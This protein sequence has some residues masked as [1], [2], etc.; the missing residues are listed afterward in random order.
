[1]HC[2]RLDDKFL[3]PI[4]FLKTTYKSE[5]LFKDTKSVFAVF[6]NGFSHTFGD[7][8]LNKVKMVDIEWAIFS[9]FD[10]QD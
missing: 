10:E 7:D 2:K 1:V 8:L 4:V 6:T 5:P 3:I 9:T